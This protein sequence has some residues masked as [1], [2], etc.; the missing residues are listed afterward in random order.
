MD[1]VVG[2]G[3]TLRS[4]DGVGIRVVE[5]LTPRDGVE[6]ALVHELTPDLVDALGRAERVLFIDAHATD[7]HLRLSPVRT[8][9][10][11]TAMGHSLSPESLLV[12]TAAACGRAPEGWL[13]AVPARS[14]D[15]GESLSPETERVVP[16][17]RRAALD[18]LEGLK[19]E[20][21]A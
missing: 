1:L 6:T 21:D 2:I 16:E 5:S 4:D 7:R 12:W 17:A 8:D 10:A 14:F 11:R 15:V 19:N 9:E 13:L 20:E 3:N 18:W